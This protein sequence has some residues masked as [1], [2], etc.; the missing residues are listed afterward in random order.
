MH[1]ERAG[2]RRAELLA[3]RARQL[4]RRPEDIEKAVGAQRKSQEANREY[5]DKHRRHRPE[6]ENRELRD[7]DLVLL[8]DTKL[9]SSQSHKLSNWW[10]GP[11][12]I[13]DTTKKGDRGTY[14]LVELDGLILEGYF[15]G[16]R[17]K[18]FIARE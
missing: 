2:N 4:E 5:F 11:Y 12:R 15:S 17:V 7:G 8:H 10:S 18:R 14:R 1:V 3:L 16:D 13:A 6:G 9:D